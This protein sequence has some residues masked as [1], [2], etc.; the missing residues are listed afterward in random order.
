MARP[1]ETVLDSPAD[2]RLPP[3]CTRWSPSKEF[4]RLHA[5]RVLEPVSGDKLVAAQ[6]LQ[7]SRATLY[8]L[9]AER[10]VER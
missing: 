3:I 5:R 7:V 10:A 2:T 8:R 4:E 6:I 9:L 1:P